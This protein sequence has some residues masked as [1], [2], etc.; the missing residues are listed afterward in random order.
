MQKRAPTLGNLLVILL[1]VLSCFGLLLFMWEAFGGSV[2]LKSKLVNCAMRCTRPV[3]RASGSAE[4]R[5]RTRS[6]VRTW[7]RS[8]C[9]KLA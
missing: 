5:A 4:T 8:S 3:K 6:P 2:P 7:P 1:F 9:G